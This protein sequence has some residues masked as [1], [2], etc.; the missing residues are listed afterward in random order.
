MSCIGFVVL[1]SVVKRRS[2]RA[3]QSSPPVDSSKNSMS[4]FVRVLQIF[5]NEAHVGTVSGWRD[6]KMTY[7]QRPLEHLPHRI[8]FC[9]SHL[10]QPPASYYFYSSTFFHPHILYYP[11][12]A[13]R[14]YVVAAFVFGLL[15]SGLNVVA[16]PSGKVARVSP[17]EAGIR[18]RQV[19][20]SSIAGTWS[21]HATHSDGTACQRKYIRVAPAT[22]GI[23]DTS[24]ECFLIYV[25][26]PLPD[27]FYGGIYDHRDWNLDDV[28]LVIDVVDCCHWSTGSSSPARPCPS[29]TS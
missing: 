19:I 18:E 16:A 15:N 13:M 4:T 28:S 12:L 23:S 22:G 17:F 24:S 14:P 27:D 21:G 20:T 2:R 26:G 8:S 25:D 29:R 11:Y 7:K 5:F 10:P 9:D 6:L 1:L 3:M